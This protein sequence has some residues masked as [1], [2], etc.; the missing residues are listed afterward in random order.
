METTCH[1]WK[2]GAPGAED[3]APPAVQT[4]GKA[5]NPFYRL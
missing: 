4:L 2:H 5:E 1:F 3:N